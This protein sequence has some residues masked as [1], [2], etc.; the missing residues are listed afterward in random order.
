M[1]KKALIN[2]AKKKKKHKVRE[3]NYCKICGR[4]HGYMRK[5]D[6]C[7]IC[8]REL[9]HEGNVPGVRKSS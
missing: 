3:F 7:R 2:K 1:P 4:N 8:F 9:V 6:I 5:F